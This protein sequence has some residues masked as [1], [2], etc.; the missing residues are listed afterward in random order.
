M[1][2]FLEHLPSCSCA[3]RIELL[4][5]RVGPDRSPMLVREE[6]GRRYFLPAPRFVGHDQQELNDQVSVGAPVG[7]VAL[8]LAL[9]FSSSIQWIARG[10]RLGL[11]L[12]A[13]VVGQNRGDDRDLILVE[14]GQPLLLREGGVMHLF[15]GVA[16]RQGAVM[17][18][19]TPVRSQAERMEPLLTIDATAAFLGVSRRQ[20]YTLLERRE[21]PH[22]RVGERTRFVPADLRAYL[23]RHREAGP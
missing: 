6:H 22:V 14:V 20:V 21:L 7:R 2:S 12:E 16:V 17:S 5:R 23:E 15:C 1:S 9:R 8:R 13:L 18:A 4:E 3:S 10:D 19:H 11:L